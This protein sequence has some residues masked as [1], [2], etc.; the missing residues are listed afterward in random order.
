MKLTNIIAGL[1]GAI[2]GALVGIIVSLCMANIL[3][4]LGA[5]LHKA[6]FFEGLS[7]I[8]IIYGS[9][10]FVVVGTIGGII[11]TQKHIK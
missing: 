4:L 6:D 9:P 1:V 3:I 11:Y 8:S 10:I 2:I 7:F 5:A